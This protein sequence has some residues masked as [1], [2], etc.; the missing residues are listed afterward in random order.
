M[1]SDPFSEARL[2][3]MRKIAQAPVLQ[4]PFPHIWIEGIFPSEFYAAIQQHLIG[5][6]GYR[7]L[8]E[9]G[10]VGKAYSAARLSLFPGDLDTLIASDEQKFFWG[11]LFD[12]F[13]QPE[14]PQLWLQRFAPTIRAHFA[15]NSQMANLRLTSEILLYRDLET[16]ALGPHTDSPAKVV[17]VLIYL[18]SDDKSEDLG[19]SFYQPKDRGF[20]CPGGP[21]HPFE[22]FERVVTMPFRPNSLLAFPKTRR[23]FHGVEPVFGERSRRDLLLFD[24]RF[25]K[26]SVS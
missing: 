14:F 11:K 7:P 9:T 6:E 18:P 25:R 21:H 1:S 8:V 17:S 5:D 10:R 2:Y 23:C 26:S 15:K 22:R 3:A 16:Y 4:R 24:I 13:V 19:T 12:A 20:E